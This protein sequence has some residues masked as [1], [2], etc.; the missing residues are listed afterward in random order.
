MGIDPKKLKVK[1]GLFGAEMFTPGLKK[2]IM[3]IWEMDVHDSYGLTEMCGPGVSTDCDQHD[4]LHLWEDHF[5]V[6]VL[7]PKTLEPVGL[8]EE[9]ELVLTTLRKDG[10]PLLRYRTRDI[11]RLY[12]EKV[13][14][15]GRTHI[16]H[17]PV[18]GRSDDML[19][20]RGTNIYP[21]Q[22]ESVLMKNPS[23]GG[24]WRM[25]LTT[26]KDIDMLRV[27]VESKTQLSQ[28]ET[29]DLEKVLKSEI[30][31]VVVFTPSVTV[32]PPNSIPQEGLKAKRVVDERK[33]V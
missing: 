33:K 18:K 10:M 22:I 12:D 7:D 8:E 17:T 23:V 3:D 2:R 9:G 19:I 28:I 16:K 31:S 5:L 30:K 4:G 1:N 13:C 11:S 15:C 24:N 14:E 6:E 21:G 32:L 26:E 27:E 20:I 25:V 29:M